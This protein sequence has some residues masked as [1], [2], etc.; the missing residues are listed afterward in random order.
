ML[1]AGGGGVPDR[2]LAPDQPYDGVHRH[3][4]VTPDRAVEPAKSDVDLALV[5]QELREL[6]LGAHHTYGRA[7]PDVRR[8]DVLDYAHP[9]WSLRRRP[10]EAPHARP[11][12]RSVRRPRAL[13]Q[14]PRPAPVPARRLDCTA[15]A[16]HPANGRR[17]RAWTG[18]Y[19]LLG[20]GP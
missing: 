2:R 12:R 16:P 18:G 11:P 20:S 8:A 15:S 4:H 6:L 14:R 5:E 3:F 9:P 1:H 17:G 19:D 13:P 10:V 7:I